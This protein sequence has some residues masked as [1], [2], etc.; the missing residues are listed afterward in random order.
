MVDVLAVNI[1]CKGPGDSANVFEKPIVDFLYKSFKSKE[2]Y[3]VSPWLSRIELGNRKFIYYP[4]VSTSSVIEILRAIMD[5]GVRIYVATRCFDFIDNQLIA[6][7]YNI[8][9]LYT[10][11]ALRT[12]IKDE[13]KNMITRMQA[14]LDLCKLAN[15]ELRFDINNM[16]HSKVY[17]NDFI[18][19]SG[20]LNFTYYGMY[21][22]YECIT[23]IPKDSDP[24]SYEI[25]REYAKKVV[26]GIKDFGECEKQV[27]DSIEESLNIR[28]SRFKDL[29][30]LLE[31]ILGRI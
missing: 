6:L 9:S 22:N 3:I 13:L 17:V 15:I 29:M 19:I 26:D 12:Y 31:E 27:L 7:A 1:I 18:A 25:L 28:L 14:T 23:I 21:R 11:E 20:S 4:Y 30:G 16:L 8:N 5:K 2:I 10:A 24:Q